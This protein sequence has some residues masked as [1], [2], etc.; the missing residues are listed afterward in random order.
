MIKNRSNY[1]DYFLII[2]TAVLSLVGF[3]VSAKISAS[4]SQ[5]QFGNTTHYLFH[6]LIYGFLFGGISGLIIYKTPLSLLKKWSWIFILTTL[7]LMLLVFAPGLG[8]SSGGAARWIHFWRFT[9]QPSEFLK[10]AFIVYISALLATRTSDSRIK[11]K[12]EFTLAPFLA[13]LGFVVLLLYFQSDLSTLGVIALTAFIIYFSSGTP[14][15]HN[16]LVALTGTGAFLVLIVFSSYRLKRVSVLL[17]LIRDPLGIGYQIKQVLIAI[18]SGGIL[19]LGL[20]A[21]LASPRIPHL[22][23]DSIFAEIGREL[24]LVGSLAI[25][26][27]YLLFFWRGVKIA[28]NSDDK[29]SQLLALGLSSWI[30]L[31]AF[32]NIGAMLGILPLTGIPLPFISYGGSHIAAELV[33]LGLML[34]ISKFKRKM[35]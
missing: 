7:F 17:G 13:V 6:Q 30:C 31:Q 20:G 11:K 4:F 24:G 22:M 16:I 34:N 26:F 2:I 10:L 32:I 15:W 28:K 1:P 14:I 9:F 19:G 25:V 23:S 35:V 33:A 3:L 21:S 8:V 29:F 5:E 12:W 27:L 18:G